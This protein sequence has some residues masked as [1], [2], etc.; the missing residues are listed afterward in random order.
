MACLMGSVG[1]AAEEATGPWRMG[2]PIVTYWAG[3]MPMTD[4]VAEQMAAGGWNLVWVTR[5]GAAQGVGA[6]EHFRAQLDVLGRH[7]L[8]GILSLGGVPRDPEKPM[9]LDDPEEKAELD[10]IVEGVREHPALYAYHILDEPTAAAFP[11][12]ARMKAYLHEKD[13][14]RLAFVNL[15]PSYASLKQLGTTGEAPEAYREY[16]NQF[17]K[18]FRP[19]LLSYD[20]YHFAV[21]GDG[22]QYFLNLAEIRQAALVADI[23]F[24]AILQACSWTVNMRIPTG[25][26]L[27]WLAYTAL[28]YGAQGIS[29]YVYGYPGHD[30]GMISPAGT[31]REPHVARSM[32]RAVLGGPPTSLYYVAREL[33]REFVAIATELR[34]MVSIGAYHVGMLPEGTVPLPDDAV[35]RLDPPVADRDYAT[36]VEGYVVGC[37]GEGTTMT[38]ALVVNL[39][40]R[41]YSGRGQERREEFLSPTRR[42]IVG[43]GPLE[44][45]DPST[46]TWTATGSN[47]A[48]LRLPPGSGLLVRRSL[49]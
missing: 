41:T 6:L 47:S 49:R 18:T 25:E 17:V 28:A 24:M 7:G 12:L 16:L 45:F 43:Q 32:G 42:K 34:P 48:E 2:A 23:P 10:A 40:T 21:K 8:R 1:T 9:A 38:H 35:F 19:Q 31:Y 46:S 20:H 22:H 3:P 27:R 39:N 26:E 44:V 29:W 33:H 5:R 14:S 11:N 30:G 15:Y 36:P 13:P 37:F 4:A